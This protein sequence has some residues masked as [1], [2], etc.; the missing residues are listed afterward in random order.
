MTPK[1]SEAVETWAEFIR[2]MELS[3]VEIRRL[4]AALDRRAEALKPPPT[5][6]P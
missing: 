1:P 6:D 2:L 3:L 4:G 5:K